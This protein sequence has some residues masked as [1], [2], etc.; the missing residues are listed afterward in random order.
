ML[1][2]LTAQGPMKAITW[3]P[4]AKITWP[5]QDHK[6]DDQVVM[7]VEEEEEE[8][9]NRYEREPGNILD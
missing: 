4:K 3:V 1:T 8:E 9:L 2:E 6:D 7:E 5:G